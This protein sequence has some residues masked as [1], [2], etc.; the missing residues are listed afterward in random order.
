MGRE[1][2]FL[3][4]PTAVGKSE[5]AVALA[6]MIGGEIISCDSMQIYK[7]M[8]ILTSA[9]GL[10]LLKKVK[11]HFIG[12]ISP[13]KDW[14]VFRYRRMALKAMKVVIAGGKIPIFVGGTGLYVSALTDGI[15]PRGGVSPAVRAKLERLKPEELALRL[16]AVDPEAAGKIHFHDKKRMVRALEVYET[17]G[18]A[19]SG[20]QK[21]RHGMAEDYEVKIFCLNMDRQSLYSRIDSRVDRMYARGLIKEARR[22]NRRRLSRTARYAIGIRELNGYFA[23][24]YPLQEAKRLIQRNSRRYAKRQLT[25]FRK[26]KRV[27]WVNIKKKESSA[28][29]ARRIYKLLN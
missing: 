29:V 2:I 8:G 12:V 18:K 20:L 14:D 21:M 3:V 24:D 19:I 7:G 25:W 15:F 6:K 10:S 26:D 22:L 11:H 17:T 9:P 27:R 16:A 1:V 28:A 13:E 5:V 23:G 4:G